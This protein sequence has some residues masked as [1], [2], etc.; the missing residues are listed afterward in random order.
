MIE[1]F[2]EYLDE[3]LTT[4]KKYDLKTVKKAVKDE[5]WQ[6]F[7]KSLKGLST[8]EKLKKLRTW[9]KNHKSGK[10]KIQ[11]QNYFYALKRGG[12]VK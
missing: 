9:K 4:G 8:Q 3:S 10:A 1:T 6:K 7:R 2:K 12:Q 11:V 5:A